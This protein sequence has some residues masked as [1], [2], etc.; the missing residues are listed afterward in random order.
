M[1]CFSSEILTSR[2]LL[3]VFLHSLVTE[4]LIQ[5]CSELS[6]FAGFLSISLVPTSD[7]GGFQCKILILCRISTYFCGLPLLPLQMRV[8]L[9]SFGGAYYPKNIHF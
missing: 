1:V 7:L 2:S 5:S 6:D 3:E 4:Q 9:E 8:T